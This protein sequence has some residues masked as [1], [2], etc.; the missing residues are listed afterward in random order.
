MAYLRPS[1]R[2]SRVHPGEVR[3]MNSRQPIRLVACGEQESRFGSH[4]AVL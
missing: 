3:E 1:A 2:L 4:S